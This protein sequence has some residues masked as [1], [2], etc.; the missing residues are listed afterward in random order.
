MATAKSKRTLHIPLDR[1]DPAT[2]RAVILARISDE[3]GKDAT[4][5]S[6][7]ANCEKFIERMGWPKPTLGP[8]T[9]KKSGYRY[10]QRPALEEVERLVQR[11]EVD[12][13]VVNDWERLARTE[14]RR[15]AAL[16]HARRYGAEYRFATLGADGRLDDTPM[17]KM[18]TS[19]MQVFGEIER[20]KIIERTS[21]GRA[22]RAERGLPTG[23]RGGAP[24]GF[25]PA[26]DGDEYTVWA[27]DGDE[28]DVLRGLFRRVDED[29]QCGLQRLADELFAR[30][31]PSPTG[32]LRWARNALRHMLRN[33]LYC[34]RGRLLRWR[35]EWHKE[36]DEE[37]GETYDVRG[38]RRRE[39]DEE[40]AYL[41]LA[42][43]AMPV[44]VEPDL[45]DRVQRKLDERREFAAKLAH[46][47]S[48]RRADATLLH[49][50]LVRCAHCGNTMVRSWRA[51]GESQAA[52]YRCNK[53]KTDPVHPHPVHAIP[54]P[55]VDDIVLGL[56]AEA[57]TNPD[58][59]VTLAD[60]AERQYARATEDT[61]RAAVRLDA[62]RERL[63]DIARDRARY[64][65]VLGMLDP[66]KDAGEVRL[67]WDKLA[68]L[69]EDQAR[70]ER[71]AA[72]AVPRHERA[73]AR[74]AMLDA[75]RSGRMLVSVEHHCRTYDLT[76]LT[77]EDAQ[78]L[79]EL[80]HLQTGTETPLLGE[81]AQ[82]AH[83]SLRDE[84]D[85]ELARKGFVVDPG[86]EVFANQTV[87]RA[88]L[89]GILL[90][91]YMPR[92][93]V[94]KLLR[95]LNVIVWVS[96]PRERGQGRTPVE[97][98]VG[99]ELL[100]DEDGAA[101]VVLCASSKNSTRF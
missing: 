70:T 75:L 90:R 63:D 97:D 22:H 26:R 89:A 79:M 40:G 6:Q 51:K 60:A 20:N 38:M 65:R 16:Y 98:R 99:V 53:G 49:G 66:D 76:N 96:R 57:L 52:H 28:A 3:S 78:Q 91:Y 37:T 1:R 44:L 35:V 19:V 71:E 21:R 4:I 62:Y 94:R 12:V 25:R 46:A 74:Q 34:G 13:V 39:E 9:E 27:E 68:K 67:Y 33:P 31:V 93:Q 81:L 7:V 92:E 48:P 15:Y 80:A 24:Y 69:D 72:T 86:Y 8:Y 47:A 56:L 41:P 83:A 32:G 43:K 5:E 11:R 42:E 50:G 29:D 30:G 84:L 58:K 23:G 100:A 95:R 36:T 54:A 77:L 2:V 59:V 73:M 17:A 64:A 14:E 101:G 18:Y 82:A 55:D 10:V 45:F 85:A 87:P 88:A 61:E